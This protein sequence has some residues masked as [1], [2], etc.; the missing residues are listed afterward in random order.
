M[1]SSPKRLFKI[2][3]IVVVTI[4]VVISIGSFWLT[5]RIEERLNTVL[6]QAGLQVKKA[7]ISLL[8]RSVDL[9]VIKYIPAD[10]TQALPHK[11]SLQFLSIEGVHVLRFVRKHDLIIERIVLEEGV[12]AYNKNFKFKRDSTSC[13]KKSDITIDRLQIKNLIIKNI[14][15]VMLDDTVQENAATIHDLQVHNLIVYFKP[16]TSYTIGEVRANLADLSSSAKGSL[17]TFSISSVSYNSND[18]QI[19]AET[20]RITPKY[21]KSDFARIARIQKTRLEIELPKIILEGVELE[22]FFSDSTLRIK[23]ITI[24]RPV[25]HAYRDKRYPFVRDW[26]MP[27]PIE[28]IRRLP[29]ALNIDSILIYQADIAYEEFSEKGLPQPGTITFNKLDASFAGLNTALKKPARKDFCTLVADCNVMNNGTLHATFKLPLNSQV[30][31]QAFGNVRNMDL[32]SLNPSL[33]NLTRFEISDGML[34]ELYFNFSYNDDV[35]TGEVLINYKDLK[36]QALKKESKSHE[37]NK[38]LT[39]AINA[40]VKSDKDKSVDKSK[41][42]GIIDIERDKKRFVFQLWWKSILD[43]LQSTFLNSGKKKKTRKGSS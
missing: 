10:S 13:E 16:D 39:A 43:G 32:K 33:G 18:K 8:R 23:R 9:Q 24:P 34:N 12:I 37:T 11:L 42:T 36:L 41:R 5:N 14:Q 38:I 30:N 6:R 15:G 4:I 17:H 27:L 22:Q 7:N 28:G 21:N 40:I 25:I 2:L 29:F 35:S 1:S 19:E 3:G 31:Y 20:F 26:I